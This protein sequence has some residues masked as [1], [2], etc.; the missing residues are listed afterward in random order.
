MGGRLRSWYGA[1]ELGRPLRRPAAGIQGRPASSASLTVV[2]S[3]SDAFRRPSPPLLSSGIRRSAQRD[4]I[5]VAGAAIARFVLAAVMLA[6]SAFG[7]LHR[8]RWPR[9]PNCSPTG[10]S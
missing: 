8:A 7:L 2:E 4:E 5:R 1:L 9:R 3:S 6:L 10:M